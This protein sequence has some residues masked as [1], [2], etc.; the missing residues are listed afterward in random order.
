ML[1]NV[2]IKKIGG[3]IQKNQNNEEL[4]FTFFLYLKNFTRPK[5]R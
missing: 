4:K 3:T 5:N 2:A 1:H